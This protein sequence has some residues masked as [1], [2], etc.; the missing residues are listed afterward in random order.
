MDL[1]LVLFIG[2][3]LKDKILI[4]EDQIIIEMWSIQ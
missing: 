2:K 4:W 1:I 3:T